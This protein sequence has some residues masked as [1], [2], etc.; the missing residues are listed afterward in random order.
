MSSNINPNNIDTAYPVAGQDNDSQGFRDNFTNIKTN[1]EFAADEI[2]D[3]QSKVV[4]K[5]ALTGTTLDN[6]MGGSVIKNAK[7]Q[8][9]RYTRI[10]PTDTTGTINIDIAAGSYYKIGQLTGNVSLN[11]PSAG[12][13]SAGNYAEW[14]VQFT[15]GGTPYTVTIPA[16]VSVGN[17]WLQG[18]N[19]NNVVTYNK[20]GTYSLKF[21]T[22]DGGSTIAVEDLSRNTDPIY[23]PSSET[24]TSNLSLSLATTTSIINKSGAWAG[25]IANGYT[26]Q[27]K[28]VIC[29]NAS[30]G[31]QVLTVASAGWKNAAAGNVTFT[32]QG[33]SATLTY[34]GGTWYCTSTGPDVSDAYPVVA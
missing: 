26:G 27:T 19:A 23:L 10:A 14:T 7:L 1:F 8:G 31:T 15:Q 20:A 24:L 21:S 30:P 12:I 25:N 29:G 28:L 32:G 6:D 34:I 33:Q 3:L 11:F 16:A 4:L 17:T 22:S 5:A 2:D 9:T 18:C 13:P